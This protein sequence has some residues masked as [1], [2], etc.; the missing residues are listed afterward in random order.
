MEPKDVPTLVLSALS[1]LV[2][3][4]TAV[5]L[6]WRKMQWDRRWRASDKRAAVDADYKQVAPSMAWLGMLWWQHKQRGLYPWA[7]A[8][9]GELYPPPLMEGSN[10]Q[11]QCCPDGKML[12]PKEQSE[13]LLLLGQHLRAVDNFWDKLLVMHGAGELALFKTDGGWMRRANNYRLLSEPLHI[14]DH[15]RAGFDREQGAYL[16][17]ENRPNRYIYLEKEWERLHP[18]QPL[19]S[20]TAW[21]AAFEVLLEK[22]M[23][24]AYTSSKSDNESDRLSDEGACGIVCRTCR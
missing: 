7:A 19:V 8:Y 13:A 12:S 5:F 23:A 6:T 22:A 4:G 20:S 14:A 17:G 21:A 18:G 2:S 10:D 24:A 9:R 16:Q 11:Q 3:L 1:L 15:Y